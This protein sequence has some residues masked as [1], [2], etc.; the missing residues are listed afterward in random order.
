MATNPIDRIAT[1]LSSDAPD[2]RIAAAVVLGELK[3]KTPGVV[4]GLAAALSDDNFAVQRHVLDALA[5]IGADKT[6]GDVMPLLASRDAGVRAAAAEALVSVGES[7]VP[8]LQARLGDAGHDERMALESVLARLGGKEAFGA[9]LS[10]LQH[11]GEEEASKAAVAMR[12]QARVA[13]ARQRKS[14]LAQLERVLAEQ[15][16]KSEPNTAAVKAAIKML[17][18]LE[19]ERALPTLLKYG[20]SKKQPG[21]IRQEALIALRFAQKNAKPDAKLLGAL[22]SAAESDDRTLAQTALITL[23]SI[24]LPARLAGRLDPLITHPDLERAR[25]IIDMLSH[26]KTED[27]AALLVQVMSEQEMRRAKLAAQALRERR[28]AAPLLADALAG[29]RDPERVRL[30]ASALRPFANELKPAQRKKLLDAAIARLASGERGIEALFE[31]AREANPKAASETLRDLYG[32]LVKKRDHTRAL[33]VLRLMCRT[34][35]AGP[36]D[37]YQL[38]ARLLGLSHLDTNAAARRSDESLQIFERL[39]REGYDVASALRRDRSIELDAL[40]YV[41]FHF[42]EE[43]HPLG[44]ELL[45]MVADKGGRKKIG[46]MAKNKLELAGAA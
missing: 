33:S 7:I 15:D 35:G 17:G 38:G 29:A 34:E 30:L 43:D 44:E 9:L 36:E 46:K 41:G 23:T 12:Q 37:R 24:D 3:A 8:R 22:V 27:S 21:P 39:I 13:D 10:G 5:R 31:V 19:D 1:M 20:S 26:R 2:K 11:A 14:Y 42:I 16:K 40:Y 4:R 25:F 6:V 32:T 18:Y 45:K 28:D